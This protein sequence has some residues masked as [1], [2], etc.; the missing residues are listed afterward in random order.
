VWV[1]E[2][3]FEDGTVGYACDGTPVDRVRLAS[4]GLIDAFEP[5]VR[6]S[7][8]NHGSNRDDDN[9]R[10]VA[11]TNTSSPCSRRANTLP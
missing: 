3:N 8:I 5:P 7:G 11:I 6:A 2:V 1:S 10:P 9:H 4:L